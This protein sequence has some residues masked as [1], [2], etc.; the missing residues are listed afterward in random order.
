VHY[1]QFSSYVFILSKAFKVIHTAKKLFCNV[2]L[3]CNLVQEFNG[4]VSK[5]LASKLA[6]LLFLDQLQHRLD[7]QNRDGYEQDK[8]GIFLQQLWL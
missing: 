6:L 7:F 1:E 5:G 4:L 2:T 3:I 8:N